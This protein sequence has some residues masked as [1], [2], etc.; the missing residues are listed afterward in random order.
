MGDAS[1]L[2]FKYCVEVTQKY[3]R[4]NILILSMTSEFQQF[5]YNYSYGFNNAQ[6]V[7]ERALKLLFLPQNHKNRSAAECSAHPSKPTPWYA[8]VA[9]VCSARGWNETI[10]VEK[11]FT[12][13]SSPSLL[14]KS[15]LVFWSHSL[16]QSDFSSDYMGRIRNELRNAAGLT[17][18]F[19][20][21]WIH[22]C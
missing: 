19:F 20:Q 5:T 22:T 16:L 17:R 8:K 2:Q 11:N 18:L 15:W 14:T 6:N 13:G 1:P 10:F 3:K 21:T 7:I 12:C 4:L 9:S